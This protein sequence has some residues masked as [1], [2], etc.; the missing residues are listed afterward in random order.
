MKVP[1]ATIAEGGRDEHKIAKRQ[2]SVLLI[3]VK[4]VMSRMFHSFTKSLIFRY[5]FQG[6]DPSAK[7]VE[8]CKFKYASKCFKGHKVIALIETMFKNRMPCTLHK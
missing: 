5:V 3:Q 4:L 1:Y 2:A 6:L 8:M 7:N